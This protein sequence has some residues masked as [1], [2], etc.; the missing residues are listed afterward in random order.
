MKSDAVMN[1]MRIKSF[2]GDKGLTSTSANHY[3]NLA[4]ECVMNLK[5]FL[6]GLQFFTTRVGLIGDKNTSV[7][8]YGLTSENLPKIKDTLEK[9][10]GL[11]SLIAFF[12]EA[13]KEKERL[14]SEAAAWE[15]KARHEEFDARY[16]E[17]MANKPGRSD[18]LTE[19]NAI[20]LWTIGEQEKYLS[21]EAKASVFGK[22]I[23]ETGSISVARR[24]LMDIIS[25]PITVQANGRDTLFYY[26]EKTVNQSEVDEMFFTLQ[27]EQREAQAELNGMKKA[28]A[29][30]I[31]EDKVNKDEEYRLATQQWN[32]KRSS[33]EAELQLI[34]EDDSAMRT[35]LSK[36]IQDLKIVVPDRLADIFN[37]LKNL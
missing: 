36:E 5:S 16:K 8:S 10:A 33:M 34:M 26:R 28:I 14:A 18:Y 19:E 4:K 7:A 23:H 2:F 11:N 17:L 1:Q 6:D 13:I 35:K 25:K 32:T 21:L 22:Y 24:Q 30:T 12:R 9:I 20:A 27:S 3:A 31:A 37:Y 15:D 29:D